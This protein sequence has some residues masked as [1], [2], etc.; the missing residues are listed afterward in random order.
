VDAAGPEDQ[1]APRRRSLARRLVEGV[2]E[3]VAEQRRRYGWF[4]H[5]ARAGGRYR[6]TQ[7]DLMAAGVTYYAFL[8]LFPMLLLLAGIAGFVLA[9]DQLLQEQLFDAIREAFP[10]ALGE[11]LVEQLTGAIG[12]AGVVGLIGL[13]GFL[14]AGLRTIDQLRI[15]MARIWKGHVEEA[16]FWRDN[17]QDALA[18]VTLGLAGTAS[19]VFTGVVTQATSSVLEFLGLAGAVG[20]G[21]LTWVIGFVLALASDVVAFLWLLRVVPGTSLPLRRLMPGALFGAAGVEALKLIGGAYLSVISQSLTASV[22][23]GAVGLLVWINLVARLGFFT[24]AWTA[25][26]QRVQLLIPRSL[27]P[28]DPA[29]PDR[30]APQR[31]PSTMR[32][33]SALLSL[34]ALVGIAWRRLLPLRRGQR[35]ERSG[36]GR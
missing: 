10:G 14:Y 13:A 8:G 15:G 28:P 11:Q 2:P 12:S 26:L 23:G 17:L 9:G 21:V 18:L 19:L 16:D 32:V 30:P 7:G 4:D 31:P 27:P 5:L 22:F 29:Q 1:P 25:T 36:G 3:V 33:L 24:A 35:R 34:G 20:Y 6:R